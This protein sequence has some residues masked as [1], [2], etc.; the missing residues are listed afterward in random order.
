MWAPLRGRRRATPSHEDGVDPTST[1]GQETGPASAGRSRVGSQDPMGRTQPGDV[2][3]DPRPALLQP[4]RAP[5]EEQWTQGPGPEG[6]K[7]RDNGNPVGS[8]RGPGDRARISAEGGDGAAHHCAAVRRERRARAWGPGSSVLCGNS[9][10]GCS[11]RR[12]TS[13]VGGFCP[14]RGAAPLRS[15]LGS[16]AGRASHGAPGSLPAGLPAQQG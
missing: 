15:I 16:K 10:H 11:G 1:A 3:Q 13:K 7:P 5:H 4:P 14:L 12:A 2:L 8:G 6:P 9:A